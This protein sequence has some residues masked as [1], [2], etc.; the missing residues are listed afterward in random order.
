MEPLAEAARMSDNGDLYVK[1]AQVHLERE[2]WSKA[3]EALEAA[4][5]KGDLTDPGNA[6]LLLGVSHYNSGK[7]SAAERSFL[8]ASNHDRQRKS[9]K[10]WIKH[11]RQEQKYKRAS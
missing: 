6:H 1:L 8:E 3:R 5:D 4:V 2:D 11:I 7:L 10:R 9:A